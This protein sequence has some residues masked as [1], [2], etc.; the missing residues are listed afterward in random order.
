MGLKMEAVGE[1]WMMMLGGQGGEVELCPKATHY[2]NTYAF[3][4][5][6]AFIK[7]KYKGVDSQWKFV[8]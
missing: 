4:R 3:M 8:N 5:L 6:Q 7:Q 1:I 2:Y